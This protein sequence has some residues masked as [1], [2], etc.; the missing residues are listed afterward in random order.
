MYIHI[1]ISRNYG[2][3]TAPVVFFKIKDVSSRRI[4]QY[5]ES[6]NLKGSDLYRI[7]VC[8]DARAN[9]YVSRNWIIKRE[10]SIAWSKGSSLF[11]G[12][13]K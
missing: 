4:A 12:A 7:F 2:S 5:A 10:E 1:R 8:I 13:E 11:C 3:S 6:L 9:K